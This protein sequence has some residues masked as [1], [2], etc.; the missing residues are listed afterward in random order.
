M[1]TYHNSVQ[2]RYGPDEYVRSPAHTASPPYLIGAGGGSPFMQR[3]DMAMPPARDVHIADPRLDQQ[4]RE[5]QL[6]ASVSGDGGTG[7]YICVT[8]QPAHV[9][10]L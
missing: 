4:R 6:R 7:L 8:G 5:H 1:R 3:F 10:L 2:G 9:P